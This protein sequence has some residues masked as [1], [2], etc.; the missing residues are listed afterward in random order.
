MSDE[1]YVH[2]P[3]LYSGTSSQV[4]RKGFAQMLAYKGFPW[5]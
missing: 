4:K 1:L 5:N 2:I 3:F